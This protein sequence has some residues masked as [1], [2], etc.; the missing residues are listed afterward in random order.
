MEYGIQHG[1]VALP[2]SSRIVFT[3]LIPCLVGGDRSQ[4]FVKTPDYALD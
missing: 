1:Q 2:C 3:R 4:E